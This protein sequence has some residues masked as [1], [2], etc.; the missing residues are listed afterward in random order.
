MEDSLA[1]GLCSTTAVGTGTPAVRQSEVKVRAGGSGTR[2]TL[3]THADVG[4]RCPRIEFRHLAEAQ[5]LGTVADR[6]HPRLGEDL[7]LGWNG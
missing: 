3:E 1:P 5:G 6:H 4:Q 7:L 2:R